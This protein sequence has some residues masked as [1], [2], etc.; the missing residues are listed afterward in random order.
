MS[1]AEPAPPARLYGVRCEEHGKLA[2]RLGLVDI[3]DQVDAVPHG[4]GDAV[5]NGHPV[6]LAA[7]AKREA[8]EEKECDATHRN[9]GSVRI[10]VTQSYLAGAPLRWSGR[11]GAAWP[12]CVTPAC[13]RENSFLLW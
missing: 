12:F 9:T 6:G 10:A 1:A 7:S 3:G 13:S 4:D 11:A 8:S 2:L 5:V